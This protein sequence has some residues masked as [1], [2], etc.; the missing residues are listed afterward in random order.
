LALSLLNAVQRS[1][2]VQGWVAQDC[3][4]HGFRQSG[5]IDDGFIDH[6]LNSRYNRPDILTHYSVHESILDALTRTEFIDP[7]R[8]FGDCL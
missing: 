1:Q 7:F 4:R 8:H 3:C 6:T 2:G 5:V